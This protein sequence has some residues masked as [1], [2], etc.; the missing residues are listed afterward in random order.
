[1]FLTDEIVGLFCWVWYPPRE[2][3]FQG[4]SFWVPRGW[5]MSSGENT[6]LFA[7]PGKNVGDVRDWITVYKVR[8]CKHK[9]WIN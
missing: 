1:M 2:V 5:G 9:I 4:V 3:E 6:V 8:E 7:R